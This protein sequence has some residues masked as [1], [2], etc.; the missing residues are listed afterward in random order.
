MW[1]DPPSH[2]TIFGFWSSFSGRE[3]L[4]RLTG[5]LFLILWLFGGSA[6]ASETR[7]DGTVIF[8]RH[9]LAP[10]SGDPKNFDLYDCQ[11][12]RNLDETGRRQAR[13]IGKRIAAAKLIFAGIYSSEWCRCLET[14]LLLE[15]GAVTPFD[16]LNS[17]YQN[18][19]PRDA[20][21]AKLNSKLTN[22][23]PNGPPVIMIT[24]YV[25]IQAVTNI[26]VPSGGAVLY[27]LTTGYARELSLTAFSSQ[28]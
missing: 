4:G 24:H 13:A 22:L 16:G 8:L 17:F 9:A 21:L 15:L 20:T 28:P 3:R 27:D 26:A 23:P 10:G 19:A 1:P 2:W 25:T 6:I 18:H 12:Q 14:A 5:L 11:T 7:F